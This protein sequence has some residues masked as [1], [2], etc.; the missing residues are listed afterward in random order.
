MFPVKHWLRRRSWRRLAGDFAAANQLQ[1]ARILALEA[2][3]AQMAFALAQAM[4][5]LDH[6][7][8]A[9]VG[10]QRWLVEQGEQ[11]PG[12]R[13]PSERRAH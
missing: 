13:S 12:E 3:F 1:Q 11:L 2:R 7:A 6:N 5:A 10:I 8:N 4:E 9:V